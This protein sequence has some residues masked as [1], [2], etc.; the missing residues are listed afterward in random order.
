MTELYS[1]NLY[2]EWDHDLYEG[3]E[4]IVSRYLTEVV[5]VFE[6]GA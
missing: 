4:R 5:P 1:D 6:T 2:V 3:T